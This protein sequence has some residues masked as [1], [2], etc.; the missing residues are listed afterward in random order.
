MSS[1][2]FELDSFHSTAHEAIFGAMNAV[3]C[4][5]EEDRLNEKEI[6]VV[7]LDKT[8]QL[9]KILADYYACDKPLDENRFASL[10]DD[11]SSDI[12]IYLAEQGW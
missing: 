1:K 2:H 8:Y 3:E 4:D 12:N 7:L 6:L 10:L 9:T 11:M 5:E